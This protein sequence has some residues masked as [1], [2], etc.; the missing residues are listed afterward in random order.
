MFSEG[1]KS[2]VNKKEKSIAL[3]ALGTAVDFP[4]D[5]AALIAVPE[6]IKFIKNNP[7][8]YDRIELFVKK[9]SEFEVYQTLLNFYINLTRFR[10]V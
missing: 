7:N 8:A 4:R 10:K 2:L 3:P 5:K 9:Q 6:I 1:L